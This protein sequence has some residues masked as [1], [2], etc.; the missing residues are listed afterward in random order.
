MGSTAGKPDGTP[1]LPSDASIVGNVTYPKFASAVTNAH[2]FVAHSY[3]G[4][5]I[6]Q[7]HYS[8]HDPFV[9][10][11]HS[12]LDRLWARWQTEPGHSA[13]MNPVTAYAGLSPSEITTLSTDHVEPWAGGTGL[14]PWA[15][16]PTKRAVWPTRPVRAAPPGCRSSRMLPA[17]SP[18]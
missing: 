1:N 8:F 17:S 13:R 18:T 3:I 9:F 6:E 16:D 15:S 7:A 5:T 11:L 10:L 2:D 14:E 4:G 12:N